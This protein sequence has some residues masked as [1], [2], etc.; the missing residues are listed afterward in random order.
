MPER[1][2][3]PTL[4]DMEEWMNTGI[5]ETTDGCSVEPDGTCPHGCNS[6]MIELGLI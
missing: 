6:W 2:E 5:A 1:T 4:G 3:Q